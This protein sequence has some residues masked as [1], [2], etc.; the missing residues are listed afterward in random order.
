LQTIRI[1]AA[2]LLASGLI[3]NLPAQSAPPEGRWR[4]RLSPYLLVPHMSGTTGIGDLQVKVDVGP[5]EI[6]SRL[7][8]GMMLSM[9]A[10]NGTWGIALDAIYMNLEESGTAGPLSAEAHLKQ[11]ALE[12]VG[13]R[14]ITAWAELLAADAA[15]DRERVADLAERF[16]G[17]RPIFG[18]GYT[19]IVC[20]HTGLPDEARAA[21]REEERMHHD[22]SHNLKDPFVVSH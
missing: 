6:L 13:V 8:F 2:L 12:L 14:R 16:A 11:G 18:T 15:G 21:V 4:F 19:A 3:T 17:S 20:T 9:E 1:A 10:N 7:Q 5:E 22:L